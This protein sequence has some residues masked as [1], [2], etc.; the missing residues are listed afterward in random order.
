MYGDVD[1]TIC[2]L[3]TLSTCGVANAASRRSASPGRLAAFEDELFRAADLSETPVVAAVAV[4]YPEGQRTVGVGFVDAAGRQLGACEFCDDDQF[5]GLDTVI[6]QVNAQYRFYVSFLLPQ[7]T[8]RDI[9]VGLLRC[10]L[11]RV[12]NA[13]VS[14]CGLQSRDCSHQVRI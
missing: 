7:L 10:H 5:C 12:K 1:A 8:A 2:N 9:T 14:Q 6:V 4:G 3:C 13:R 11:R